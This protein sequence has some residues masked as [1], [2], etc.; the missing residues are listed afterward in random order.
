MLEKK[1]E[2]YNLKSKYS[3]IYDLKSYNE[4]IDVIPI[5]LIKIE[6][7]IMIEAIKVYDLKAYEEEQAKMRNEIVCQPKQK[8]VESK[9]LIEAKNTILNTDPFGEHRH[10]GQSLGEIVSN[11]MAWVQYA[12]ENMT[13]EYIKKR[14]KIIVDSM[15]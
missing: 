14:L 6:D 11:D 13:N 5:T 1:M 15:N 7:I 2:I 12:L 4:L 9:E 8:V 10:S 3:V